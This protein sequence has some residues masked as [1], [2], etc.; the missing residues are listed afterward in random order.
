MLRREQHTVTR[1]LTRGAV[2]LSGAALLLFGGN[3]VVSAQMAPPAGSASPH[4]V[5][6]PEAPSQTDY[7]PVPVAAVPSAPQD[8]PPQNGAQGHPAHSRHAVGHSRRDDVTVP[9]PA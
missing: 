3:A 1:V 8:A 6:A 2:A 9:A 4:D 5:G 7:V